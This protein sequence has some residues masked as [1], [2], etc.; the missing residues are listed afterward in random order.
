M[1]TTPTGD[2]TAKPKTPTGITKPK[3]P[4]GIPFILGNEFAERLSFF[5]MRSILSLFLVTQF[6]NPHGIESLTVEANARSN[7]YTHAFSSL[8]YF[9]PLLGAILADWFFGKYRVILFGSIL[10]TFGHGMLSAFHHSLPGFTAGLALIGLAAGGIK[11][12][13]P[14]NVGDQFDH[15]N[16]SLMSRFYGWYY[17]AVNAGGTVSVILIPV[18]LEKYGPGWAFGIPGIVMALATIAFYAGHKKYVKVP[19]SGVKKTRFSGINGR[20]LLVFAFIP[21]YWGMYDMS[22]SEWVLQATKLNLDLGIF[23]IKALPAQIQAANSFL[24]LVL[25]PVFN[26]GI[27]PLLEKWGIKPTP[28]RKIGTG[29]L[30]TALTFVIIALLETSIEAGGHPSIGWQ[31]LAYVLLSATEVMVVIT[32]LEYAYT[33]SPPALKSTMTALFFF[34]YSVGTSF[35]TWVNVS[36]ATHGFFHNFTGARYYWL[37]V[38]IMLVFTVL[39]AIISPF[40]KE[41]NYLAGPA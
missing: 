23:G 7:A 2:A 15:T 12:C 14:A 22:Q 20:V 11:S 27:Y 21:I 35:T 10:Y 26:Y 16:Q 41:S 17:F 19:A 8:V 24:L 31:I 33:Q 25:I 1:N 18:V 6:F 9:T 32:C 29:L 38:T 34:T 28:L 39:F 13:V 4:A 37:F 30:V 3:I 36:I 40:I 5:G